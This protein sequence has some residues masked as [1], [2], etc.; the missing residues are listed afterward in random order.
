MDGLASTHGR[1]AI[2]Y[3][4]PDA[5]ILTVDGLHIAHLGDFGQTALTEEQR[6][7]LV[8]I[9]VLIAP[10]TYLLGSEEKAET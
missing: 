1:E 3:A 2:D 6:R 10:C 8:G 4:W 5:H 7:L 9:D